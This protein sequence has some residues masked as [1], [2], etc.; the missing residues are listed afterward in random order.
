ME[1]S[2]PFLGEARITFRVKVL[3]LGDRAFLQVQLGGCFRPFHQHGLYALWPIVAPGDYLDHVV[4]P[5]SNYMHLWPC[6]YPV[7]LPTLPLEV[8]DMSPFA[9]LYL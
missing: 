3:Y 1:K 5:K 7:A 4:S 2:G 8:Q 6:R 9:L